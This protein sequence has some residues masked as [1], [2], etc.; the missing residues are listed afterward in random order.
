M[1][2]KEFDDICQILLK[3]VYNETKYAPGCAEILMD[4][5]D[6]M[7]D[8]EKKQHYYEILDRFQETK[9]PSLQDLRER[10]SRKIHEIF[11]T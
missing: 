9:S 3:E 8:Y 5:Y 1:Y 4:F 7:I 10:A 11:P 6:N 2:P